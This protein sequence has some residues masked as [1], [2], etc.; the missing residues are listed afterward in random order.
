MALDL[1]AGTLTRYYTRS[2]ENVVERQARLDGVTYRRISPGGDAPPPPAE[3][4]TPAVEAWCAE[5]TQAL[6]ANISEPI[7]WD[8]ADSRPYFTDRP[9]WDGYTALVLWAAY[10]HAPDRQRPASLPEGDFS[11]DPAF[12]AMLPRESGTPYRQILQ[13]G[14][15]L[16]CSYNFAFNGP[17][18]TGDSAWMGSTF[19][20]RDQLELLKRNTFGA[21]EAADDF[22]QRA[23]FALA[24]FLE[25]SQKACE[26]RVPMLLDF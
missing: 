4:V 22:Q 3:E 10:A 15:W 6:G 1:Y 17:A 21:S 14:L 7:G 11:E 2:W 12:L 8:E 16:P 5:L 24:L 20:L 19:A 23:S 18:L 13:P 25:L 9:G 26:A